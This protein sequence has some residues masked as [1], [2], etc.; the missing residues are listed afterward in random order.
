V[1]S[2]YTWL[3]VQVMAKMLDS[4]YEDI[5][6]II[7]TVIYDS[8]LPTSSPSPIWGRFEGRNSARPF[9]LK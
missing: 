1:F 3:N 8:V 7:Y 4:R 6:T 5:F 9:H 2:L